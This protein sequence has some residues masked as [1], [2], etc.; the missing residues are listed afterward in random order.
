MDA[1]QVAS[2]SNAISSVLWSWVWHALLF[3]TTFAG[4]T[5]LLIRLLRLRIGS[6]LEAGLWL[7]VLIKFLI[8][9]GP[10]RAFSL[11]NFWRLLPR[12]SVHSAVA[13]DPVAFDVGDFYPVQIGPPDRDAPA[14]VLTTPG[15]LPGSEDAGFVRWH[16]VTLFGMVYLL[17]VLSLLALRVRSYHVLVTRCRSLPEADGRTANVVLSVCRRLGVRRIPSVRLSNERPSCVMGFISPLLIVSRHLL[18]RPD[19]L[20]TVI[21][22]EIAHLRRGDMFVRYIECAAGTLFFFWPV[23]VWINRRLDAA[24]EY[25]CDEWALRQRKLTAPEYAR[26]LLRAVQP[27]RRRRFAYAPCNM[28]TT[29]QAIERRIDMILQLQHHPS[30]RGTGRLW[31]SAFVLAWAAF[32]LGGAAAAPNRVA[33]DQSKWATEEAVQRRAAALYNL[34]GEHE[35]ADFNQDGVLSYLEKDTYLVAL[36]MRNAA[37]FMDEFPYADRN[38]SGNLDILEARDVIRAVTLV[39]YADR[40]TC[41]TTEHVLPLEFCHAALDAQAWLLANMT[42]EPDWSELDITWSVLRRVQGHP[43]SI[44]ARMLD[45]GAPEPVDGG[46]KYDRKSRRLFHELEVGIAVMEDRL[47]NAQDPARI[48]RL[49]SMLAKLEAILLKL[50]E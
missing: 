50:H 37:L 13:T 23:V 14:A 10:S 46:R 11:S 8:P 41:A 33:Y 3:G 34:V 17:C 30:N 18:V 28:A 2:C 5:Y 12:S 47:A 22:H 4:L 15:P 26:C 25:A 7:I 49:E 38:H 24:R 48:A 43:T 6:A 32:T 20:E 29:R 36:A 31:V 45:Q 19:E 21:V 42:S 16:W 1:A 40:R 39:A 9:F 35:V 44:S 27:V